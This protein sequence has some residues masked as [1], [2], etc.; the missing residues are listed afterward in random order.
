MASQTSRPSC[1]TLI[2]GISF[3]IDLIA[4]AFSDILFHTFCS[5]LMFEL[6]RIRLGDRPVTGQNHRENI[7]N[8]VAK[9][10]QDPTHSSQSNKE[11]IPANVDAVEQHRPEAV[12]VEVQGVFEQHR[13][14]TVLQ[15]ANFRRHLENIIRD[16]IS[17]AHQTLTTSSR[18]RS[19]NSPQPSTQIQSS[20]A[21]E[22][23]NRSSSI[24]EHISAAPITVNQLPP[25]GI[26]NA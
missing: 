14:S 2:C 16:S 21:D 18:G 9:Y 26:K 23:G 24:S 8:F 20:P 3:C 22:D 6:R 15:S 19:L 11:T 10:V 7:A 12:I 5:D 4:V 1:A 17:A 13:V 25:Q